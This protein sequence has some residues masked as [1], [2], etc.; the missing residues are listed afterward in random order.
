MTDTGCG[1][2]PEVVSKAFEPFF[3]TKE[4]GKGTGL[5]LSI[6]YGLAV[7]AGGTAVI[8]TRP[9]AGTSVKLFF[10]RYVADASRTGGRTARGAAHTGRGRVLVIDASAVRAGETRRV[11]SDGGFDVAV[12]GRSADVLAAATSPEAPDLVL[13]G[14]L[15]GGDLAPVALAD[16]LR[17][18]NDFRD[19]A[20][21]V[22]RDHGN[23]HRALELRP[24]TVLDLLERCDAL[25]RPE[26]FHEF[27]IACEADFRGRTGFESRAYPQAEYLRAALAAASA[28][29]L[30]PGER[31]G[32]DGA[33]IGARLR[34]R[35]IEALG[36]LKR[37]TASP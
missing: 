22:A 35:R 29:A 5:G 24:G 17:V 14:D 37:S 32:L 7:R 6:V 15:P 26:R 36:A 9:G 1:M 20:I 4:P 31:A 30:A 33:T 25:R 3:T 16:R 19:L 2:P 11:L 27:L 21:A 13:I 12:L 8:D 34:E 28:A 10:P 18:P 23:C